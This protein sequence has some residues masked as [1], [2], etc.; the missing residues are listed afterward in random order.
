MKK[1]TTTL[2]NYETGTY[3][4][5]EKNPLVELVYKLEY[6]NHGADCQQRQVVDVEQSL[7]ALKNAI[8]Q[9]HNNN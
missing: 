8:N 5:I 1:E 4:Q 7:I 6:L 9:L 3:F 2:P